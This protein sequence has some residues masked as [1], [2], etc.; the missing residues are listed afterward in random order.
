MYL[1]HKLTMYIYCI[2]TLASSL[3][4]DLLGR[5]IGGL[6]LGSLGLGFGGGFDFV[7]LLLLLILDLGGAGL[8]LSLLFSGLKILFFFNFFCTGSAGGLA[9]L[10]D[11][12]LAAPESLF[13][14]LCNNFEASAFLCCWEGTWVLL[15]GLCAFITGATVA[16]AFGFAGGF[17]F[18]EGL[19]LLGDSSD[20]EE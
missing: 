8:S 5:L 11:N 18:A 14:L 9:A 10:S 12:L 6:A 17:L 20:S 15:D 4:F 3:L 16:V 19:D 7:T 1:V 13:P 2:L